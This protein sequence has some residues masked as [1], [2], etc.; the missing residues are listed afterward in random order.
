[1]LFEINF[2]HTF[3]IFAFFLGLQLVAL[4]WYL[5]CSMSSKLILTPAFNFMIMEI[6]SVCTFFWKQSG[7]C[8]IC[9]WLW[10]LESAAETDVSC[11]NWH[12]YYLDEWKWTND[13]WPDG[14]GHEK[15]FYRRNGIKWSEMEWSGVKWSGMKWNGMEW[16][17]TKLMNWKREIF[18][19]NIECQVF[20][21]FTLY[22]LYKTANQWLVFRLIR[23][24]FFFLKLKR[25]KTRLVEKKNSSV[26]AW[27]Q[28]SLETFWQIP[29]L[30][31][32]YDKLSICGHS[33]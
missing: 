16:V 7:S 26:P 8:G 32:A 23:F 19:E 12:N 28:N 22:F 31:V 20:L 21:I 1:M 30:R 24:F 18:L 11:G 3:G 15:E 13:K 6:T 33:Q 29:P 2:T 5:K 4:H 17:V 9:F 27:L 25:T 10:K 14:N